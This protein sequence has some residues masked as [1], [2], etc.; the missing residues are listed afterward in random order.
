MHLASL[1]R[2]P[3]RLRRRLADARLML[4]FTPEL[5]ARGDPLTVLEAALGSVD[6]VQ[7]RPKSPAASAPCAARETYDWCV[8]V[9]DLVSGRP[10]LEIPVIVDDRVDVAAALRGRGCAGVHLGQDDTPPAL[11]RRILGPD[12]LIGRSTHDLR[13]VAEAGEHPIDYLGFGPIHPTTTKGYVESLGP[14]AAWIASEGSVL[15]VFPIG[16][17][18]ATNASELARIGRAAVGSAILC[19]ED[20]E[21]AAREIRTLLLS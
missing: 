11:A 17:I 15:P 12:L 18:D 9:L 2:D 14:E 10:E 1:V 21:R 19:A 6:I 20:P 5:C 13:Q 8:R 7:I 3:V 16:G 4:L